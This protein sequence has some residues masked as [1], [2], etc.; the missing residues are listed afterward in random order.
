M[1][2]GIESV[3]REEGEHAHQEYWGAKDSLRRNAGMRKRASDEATPLLGDRQGN[4]NDN[5][6]RGSEWEGHADFEGLTWWHKPS[7]RTLL[8][9]VA[10]CLD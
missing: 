5:S 8:F 3:G 9:Y 4:D 10:P 7:V 6:R 2:D 1:S